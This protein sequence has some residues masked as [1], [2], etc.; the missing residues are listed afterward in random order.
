MLFGWYRILRTMACFVAKSMANPVIS[1]QQ[2]R[3]LLQV[4][5]NLNFP[6]SSWKHF[7]KHSGGPENMRKLSIARS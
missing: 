1:M 5:Q 7:P 3:A 4:Y 6:V 2:I